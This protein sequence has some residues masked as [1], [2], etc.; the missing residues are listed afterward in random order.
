MKPLR[1]LAFISF[2]ILVS[3]S[4]LTV[5]SPFLHAQVPSLP[6]PL[7]QNTNLEDLPNNSQQQ[8]S[9]EC[10]QGKNAI[11]VEAKDVS[12]WKEMIEQGGW[13]CQEQLTAISEGDLKFSCDP[14][15]PIGLLTVVWL[16]GEGGKQQMQTW[17]DELNNRQGMVCRMGKVQPWGADPS[18]GL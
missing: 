8:R 17:I 9:W 15:E 12:I 6:K 13:E 7:N 11:E 4:Y 10:S 3:A 16:S 5:G 2:S 1:Q 14:S 18:L